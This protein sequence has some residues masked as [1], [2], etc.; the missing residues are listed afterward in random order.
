MSSFPANPHRF[1][2]YKAFKFRVILEGRLV[3]GVSRV[4]TLR[5]QTTP[6]LHRDG[7]FSSHFHAGPGITRFDPIT[8]ERGVAHDTIFEDWANQA[9][10]PL[11]DAGISLRDFRKDLRIDLLNEQGTIALSYM[12]FR[13]WVSAYQALPDLDANANQV[14]IE[15][16]ELQHEGWERD[17]A[18]G[19]PLET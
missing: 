12:V 14:A 17:T 2:P 19:E 9:F 10:S 15:S 3:P 7:G 4:S 16:I 5:R 11:G 6:V 13:A 1:D 8:L 18:V